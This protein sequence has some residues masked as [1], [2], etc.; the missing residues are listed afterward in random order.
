MNTRDHSGPN[1][2]DRQR[3]FGMR[4]PPRGA[5]LVLRSVAGAGSGSGSTLAAAA[6]V[7]IV[8]SSACVIS[9]LCVTFTPTVQ[10]GVLINRRS[11]EEV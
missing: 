2:I 4:R 1:I 9:A 8:I 10:P 5:A 11:Q 6:K 7:C 3:R